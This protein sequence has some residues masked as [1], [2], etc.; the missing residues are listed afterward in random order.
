VVSGKP[1]DKT[2]K[3]ISQAKHAEPAKK[4]EKSA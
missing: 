1:F 3:S 2:F 4:C